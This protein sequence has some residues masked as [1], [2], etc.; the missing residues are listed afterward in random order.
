MKNNKT[1]ILDRIFDTL[2]ENAGKDVS[3]PYLPINKIEDAII[4]DDQNFIFFRI[5]KKGYIL[6]IK[7]AGAEFV[8]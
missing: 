2:F 5:G 1:E 7:N 8:F 3:H 4:D 6:T